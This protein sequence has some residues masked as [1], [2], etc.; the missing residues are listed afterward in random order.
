MLCSTSQGIIEAGEE[1]A[2]TASDAA[3]GALDGSADGNTVEDSELAITQ[4]DGWVQP[5]AD[6]SYDQQVATARLSMESVTTAKY[7]CDAYMKATKE[8]NAAIVDA[9]SGERLDIMKQ[10]VN[11]S[12]S[13]NLQNDH[14]DDDSSMDALDELSKWY[15]AGPLQHGTR[16]RVFFFGTRWVDGEI[17]DTPSAS[18][19]LGVRS[20]T[21]PHA[22]QTASAAARRYAVK[23]ATPAKTT[24]HC[25]WKDPTAVSEGSAAHNLKIE[26][27]FVMGGQKI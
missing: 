7:H 26:C 20:T 5:A 8:A 4:W 13:E 10:C 1:S 22:A 17:F 6:A 21:K 24:V 27:K 3:T 9:L 19:N 14:P 15:R 2:K 23:Q 11:V 18:G 12:I 25:T 16:V